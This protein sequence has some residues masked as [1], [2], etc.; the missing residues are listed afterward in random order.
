MNDERPPLVERLVCRL[1]ESG[2]S[3]ADI[4]TC[5]RLMSCDVDEDDVLAIVERIER[6]KRHLEGR[7][8]RDSP[9]RPSRLPSPRPFS[10]VH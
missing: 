6:A 1:Y 9:W 8:V 4:V 2:H 10:H 7:A 3:L 5:C